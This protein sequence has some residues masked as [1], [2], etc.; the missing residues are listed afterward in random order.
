MASSAWLP[1]EVQPSTS[2]APMSGPAAGGQSGGPLTSN[3]A[4]SVPD[5]AVPI[6]KGSNGS[7]SDLMQEFAHSNFSN[8]PGFV[9]P[10]FSY[11]TLPIANTSSGGSQQSSSSTVTNPNPTPT[12][13][14][15]IQPHVSGLSMPPS[16]SF[17]YI[18]QTGVSFSTSQQFQAST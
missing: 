18:S 16:S 1:Q 12:S 17:S 2:Q 3:V 7:S 14:M 9:V 4:P 10:A 15:V 8:T 6:S 5:A 13:P 11:S